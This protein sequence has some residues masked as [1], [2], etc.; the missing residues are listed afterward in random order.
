[1]RVNVTH[2]TIPLT[3]NLELLDDAPTFVS[4]GPIAHSIVIRLTSEIVR[5]NVFISVL[6]I[7]PSQCRITGGAIGS[8]DPG[9]YCFPFQ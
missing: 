6:G 5:E 8:I 3:G 4:N 7:V 9:R 2:S 1:M